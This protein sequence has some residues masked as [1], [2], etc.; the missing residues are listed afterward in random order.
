[1]TQIP[2]HGDSV[3]QGLQTFGDS[4]VQCDPHRHA[5]LVAKQDGDFLHAQPAPQIVRYHFLRQRSNESDTTQKIPYHGDSVRMARVRDAARRTCT[6]SDL[7]SPWVFW[8]SI[9]RSTRTAAARTGSTASHSVLGKTAPP[10]FSPYRTG[11]CISFHT[12][13]PPFDTPPRSIIFS[14]L[15]PSASFFDVEDKSQKPIS[16]ESL[17]DAICQKSTDYKVL[18]DRAKNATTDERPKILSDPTNAC[19]H[20]PLCREHII[21]RCEQYELLM[22]K[23]LVAKI[24]LFVGMVFGI[25]GV[26]LLFDVGDVFLFDVLY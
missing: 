12:S 19:A 13:P 8:T 24:M 4:E 3:V 22:G 21:F 5:G 7:R 11:A 17:K 18:L 9:P 15:P 25:V 14:N 6:L 16:W 26:L 2:Y 23:L 10:F 1:M 20:W